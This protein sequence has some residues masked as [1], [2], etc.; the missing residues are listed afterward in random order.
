[1]APPSLLQPPGCRSTHHPIAG[2]EELR[3]LIRKGI[4]LPR[5]PFNL[6]SNIPLHAEPKLIPRQL[7]DVEPRAPAIYNPK[8][9]LRVH[10]EHHK[11]PRAD[12]QHG[13]EAP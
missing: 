2:D 8:Q 1:V 7:V 13:A 6:D 11:L 10:L 5:H 12:M 3:Q 9:V 4:L